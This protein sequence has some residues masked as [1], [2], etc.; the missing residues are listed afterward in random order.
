M[1]EFDL[2]QVDQGTTNVDVFPQVQETNEKSQ[3]AQAR[4][5]L[6][7]DGAETDPAAAVAELNNPK[8]KQDNQVRVQQANEKNI[9]DMMAQLQARLGTEAPAGQPQQQDVPKD[10][11]DAA[12]KPDAVENAVVKLVD[13]N[14]NEMEITHET[15]RLY[16]SAKIQELL[17]RQGTGTK[18]LDALGVMFVPF[19]LTKDMS[20]VG[21][22]HLSWTHAVDVEGMIIDYQA[23]DPAEKVAV[24]PGLMDA[25]LTATGTNIAG[26]EVSEQN[27]M[28]AASIL[29]KFLHPF[30]EEEAVTERRWDI[31]FGA[32]D[33]AS[34]KI[35]KGVAG[36]AVRNL[37]QRTNTAAVAARL[38]NKAKAAEATIAAAKN[39]TMA[40]VHG[41]DKATVVANASP[42]DRSA[43]DLAYAPEINDAIGKTLNEYVRQAD[44]LTRNIIEDKDLMRAGALN[45]FE[46]GQWIESWQ[47]RLYKNVSDEFNDGVHVM[48]MKIKNVTENG[49]DASYEIRHDGQLTAKQLGGLRTKRLNLERKLEKDPRNA[50][51]K[52]QL[53]NVTEA[54][55]ADKRRNPVRRDETVR[56]GVDENGN[57]DYTGNNSSEAARALG[58][59]SFWSYTKAGGDFND[60]FK[61]AG[62]TTDLESAFAQHLEQMVKEAWEPV[63]ALS[64]FKSRKRVSDVLHA[65]DVYMNPNG[66]RG[67]VYN[68]NELVA[69]VDTGNGIVRLTDPREIE[70][71]YR[72]RAAA[73]NFWRIENHAT[74]RRLE[75]NGFKNSI[76]MEEGGF[77]AVR[78]LEDAAHAKQ[79]LRNRSAHTGSAVLDH[80]T[81]EVVDLTDDLID[82]QYASGRVLVRTSESKAVKQIDGST[83]YVDYAFVERG[84]LKDLP[85][86]VIHF[87]RGYIPKINKGVEY[88]VKETIPVA[89]RGAS[90]ASVQKTLRFFA[91]KKDA[92]RFAEKMR[93]KAVDEGRYSTYEEA[94]NAIENVAD[95]ELT[96]M[97]RV[98]TP[99]G[100]SGGL[101]SGARSSDDIL[102]GLDGAYTERV[103]VY[104]AMVRNARHTGS[105]V[106]RNE[107]RIGDEQRWLNTVDHLLPGSNEGFLG[108]RLPD[109]RIGRSLSAMREQIK[110]WNGVPQL[111]ETAMQG[112]IQNI[113]DWTLEG[114]RHLPGLQNKQSI[115]RLL[116]LKHNDLASALKT[117]TMH[118][119]LGMLTPAQLAVQA[120]AMSVAITRYPKYTA[121]LTSYGFK[122]GMLDLVRN[123]RTMKQILEQSDFGGE[124]GEIY[125]AWEKSGLRESVYA[126]ADLVA[127]ENYGVITSNVLKKLSDTS[128]LFYRNGELMNR[129][130]AFITSYLEHRHL[131]PTKVFDNGDLL[132][133]R[134]DANLTMLELNHANRA[135]WQGGPQSGTIR[136]MLGVM[137]QFQQVA[138]K[139]LELIFKGQR[140]G[141]FT[142]VEKMRILGGQV[143]LFGAAGVPF[144]G[145]LAG[146]MFRGTGAD[147]G[148][149]P[150]E[151]QD[152]INTWNQGIIIGTVLNALDMD[153]DVANRTA[154][155][156]QINQFVKDLLFDDTPLIEKFFGVGYDVGSR[157]MDAFRKIYPLAASAHGAHE[158]T[159]M[160]ANIALGYLAG[161]PSSGR[162][163]LKAWV[164]HNQHVIRDRHGNVVDA[165]NYNAA[166]EAA[167]A[168][169]F[170]PSLDSETRLVQMSNQDVVKLAGEMA[171]VYVDLSWQY[172]NA[173]KSGEASEAKHA[174]DRMV[175]IMAY[176]KATTADRPNLYS[177]VM[178][179]VQNKLTQKKTIREKALAEWLKNQIPADVYAGAQADRERLLG[180]LGSDTAIV[181]PLA[182]EIEEK[183]RG[184]K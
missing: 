140:R 144:L 53:D 15:A 66:S 41:I 108:T 28:Q 147:K 94:K 165:R 124:F 65:G 85:Q 33:L 59:P 134:K 81:G 61:T 99:I 146:D 5:A 118:S 183:S 126:N 47:Q 57:F 29:T 167:V 155:F 30:G 115:K 39:P 142:P 10:V 132:A 9:S 125:R 127:S 32:L 90:N 54:L 139:S 95:R 70:S 153:V 92:E 73:D 104:E 148:V 83:Q 13:K 172:M 136:Q 55:A 58:S 26:V 35:V 19:G 105:L 159:R 46:K 141:G 69:G 161:I 129:R 93:Q 130:A 6:V 88:L 21:D 149:D 51:L 72:M 143:A 77:A 163:L 97:Q 131:N 87:K 135:W 175:S 100:S 145:P 8:V 162:N 102:T 122:M 27:V 49:F 114:V 18:V 34:L 176:L 36:M 40:K 60:S 20:D 71:Y 37:A 138:A 123:K 17:D 171:D 98:H 154:A 166:T 110:A 1:A 48:N 157:T 25:V 158:L 109:D 76:D 16:A 96:P 24:F 128:M 113:H 84:S 150:K 4:N 80:S 82:Q 56:F 174:S 22:T 101:F 11:Q 152:K 91:S 12:T 170:R 117:A 181:A 7:L 169:G 14:G 52:Q 23:L 62:V 120:S 86:Q 168:M 31:A 173:L 116:W 74:R 43:M 180:Q 64:Q 164:M 160:D 179:S 182:R 107:A 50:D 184:K 79:S 38:G 3:A 78:K 42:V 68:V 121:K 156:G 151:L 112:L 63:G 89:K 177:K 119:V 137:T 67:Y 103:G 111:D 2:S 178:N 75:L 45:D 106:A 133:I 44:Q